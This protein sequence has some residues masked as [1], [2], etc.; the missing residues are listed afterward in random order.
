MTY[1]LEGDVKVFNLPNYKILLVSKDQLG[2]YL[3]V[4]IE[5]QDGPID[6]RWDVD[7]LTYGEIRSITRNNYFDSLAK[8]YYF[9]LLP[10][11]SAYKDELNKP[12]YEGTIRCV[13]GDRAKRID[14]ICSEQ[15]AGNLEWL[16]Q[17]ERTVNDLA[18]VR[19]NED[20]CV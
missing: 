1:Q 4:R 9:E 5:L 10:F 8:D 20:K 6:I 15:F 7:E 11:A 3:K 18:I 16:R 12:T 19:W 17:Q 13:Q 2:H 14:F